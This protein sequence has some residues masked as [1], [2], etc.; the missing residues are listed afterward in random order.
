MKQPNRALYSNI[1]LR[2]TMVLSHAET[3]TLAGYCQIFHQIMTGVGKTF[4]VASMEQKDA[5]G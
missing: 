5:A 1:S 2:A 3:K 4:L